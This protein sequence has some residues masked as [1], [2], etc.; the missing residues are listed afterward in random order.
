MRIG[1]GAL[2][3][4]EQE[5]VRARKERVVPGLRFGAG[6]GER[7]HL[8]VVCDEKAVEAELRPDEVGHDLP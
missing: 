4:P 8:Q 2:V 6:L 5:E 1:L 7:A 3:E